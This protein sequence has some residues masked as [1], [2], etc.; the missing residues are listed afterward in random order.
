MAGA[1]ILTAELGAADFSWIEG[2]RRAHYP[3][4]RNYVPAHL[5][6]FHALAPSARRSFEAVLHGSSGVRRLLRMSKG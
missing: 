5:T 1:L 3:F 6:I 2:L 4:D